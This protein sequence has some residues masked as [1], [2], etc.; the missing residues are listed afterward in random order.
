MVDKLNV[1]YY[2]T[3]HAT[4]SLEIIKY[5]LQLNIY[6]IH[7]ITTLNKDNIISKL[8]SNNYNILLLQ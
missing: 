4:R 6:I 8:G 2:M 5:L 7:I 1:C 3:G